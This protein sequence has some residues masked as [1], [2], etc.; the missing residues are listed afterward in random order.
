[1]TAESTCVYV[2]AAAAPRPFSKRGRAAVKSR[3]EGTGEGRSR[4]GRRE[5][6]WKAEERGRERRRR[7][8]GSRPRERRRRPTGDGLITIVF[9]SV[10]CLSYFLSLRLPLISRVRLRFWKMTT[11]AKISP[12]PPGS[13]SLAHSHSPLDL[14][15]LSTSP[16]HSALSSLPTPAH[17][18]LV[19]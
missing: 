4:E 14:S 18:S 6:R 9:L 16:L 15:L 11:R 17:Y 19:S 1:M 2:C 7:K 8:G 12:H 5:K 10:V 13:C 3:W